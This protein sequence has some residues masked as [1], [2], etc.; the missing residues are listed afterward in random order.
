MNILATSL[1]GIARS[2]AP[3]EVIGD[4]LHP[5]LKRWHI[6]RDKDV[7]N[8]YLHQFLRSDDE[9]ALHD[10]PWPS[11]S[12]LLDGSYL[13]ITPEEKFIRIPGEVISREAGAPHRVQLLRDEHGLELPVWTLFITGA[14]EREWGFFCEKGWTHWTEFEKTGC[15]G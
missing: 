12:I 7:C 1:I 8:I 5:Y 9:R 2:R 3:D 6:H 10:H 11:T 13:E 14:K 4:W 15:G